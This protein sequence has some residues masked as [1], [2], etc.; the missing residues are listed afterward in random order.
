[1]VMSPGYARE[2]YPGQYAQ[3][4]NKLWFKGLHNKHGTSCCDESDCHREK[5]LDGTP[6][7]E[8]WWRHS[9][10]DE[11]YEI[12]TTPYG[13]WMKVPDYA[14]NPQNAENPTNGALACFMGTTIYCFVPPVD[15]DLPN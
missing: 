7:G 8:F 12:R 4:P 2:Q 6:S 14:V 10:T 5:K 11:G 9:E 15:P 13:Q 3:S 1:M